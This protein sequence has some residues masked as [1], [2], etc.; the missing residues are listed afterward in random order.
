MEVDMHSAR[1]IPAAA[2]TLLALG[3]LAQAPPAKPA[4]AWAP[5]RFLVGSWGGSG[6]G[7]PGE[8]ITGGTTFAFDLGGRILVRKNRAEAAPKAGDKTAGIHED[9]MVV[10]PDPSDGKLH[11]IYFDNEGHVI[12]YG[13]SFPGSPNTAVF[14]SDPSEKGPRFRLTYEL[15]ADGTLSVDFAI[16]PPGGEFKTYTKGALKKIP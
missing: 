6:S 2:F 4:D 8:A 13:V 16:A 14:E 5:L 1:W 10:Y 3:S 7:K 9:L 12:R 11:A 15:G